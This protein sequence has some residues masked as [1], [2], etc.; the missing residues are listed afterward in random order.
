[1][2]SRHALLAVLSLVLLPACEEKP[3]FV[4]SGRDAGPPPVC[5]GASAGLVCLGDVA[6]QC[7]ARGVASMPDDCGGRGERCVPDVGCRTCVPREVRCDG[8]TIEVCDGEESG[9]M[10]GATCDASAGLRCSADGCVDLCAR[11]AEERSYLGCEYWPVVTANA[12]LRSELSF[13]VAI[14]NPQLVPALVRI[15]RGGTELA[16]RTIAPGALEIVELPWIES[17][18]APPSLATV[19]EP[20]GAYHLV[21]DVP[22][23]V[24]QWS[25]LQ[26][27]IDRD[28]ADEPVIGDRQ[29]F[30]Y[31]NDASLLLPAHVLTGNYV[32]V[33]RPTFMLRDGAERPYAASPGFASIVGAAEGEVTVEIEARGRVA[34]SADGTFAAMMPGETRTVTLA[35]GEV[36]Q[37]AS[38][39]AERCPGTERAESSATG[40]GVTYCDPGDAYD[41]SG[42]ILRASG[43]VAVVAG[44]DCTFVPFDRWACDHLEEQLFPVE[45]LGRS[46]FVAPTRPLREEPNLLR[47]VSAADDN[48]ITFT[49]AIAPPVTLDRGEHVEIELREGVRVE[50]TGALLAALFLVGQDY[51]GL[52]TSGRQGNGDPSMALAIPDAQYRTRYTVLTPDSYRESWIDV[53]APAGARIEIDGRLVTGWREIAGTGWVHASIQVE[54][55]AHAARGDR[56]F[57]LQVYGFGAYTSY[58]VSGGLDLRPIA[59][60]I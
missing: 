2:T 43:P 58:L 30:S 8:E 23:V 36:L 11:A 38:E 28:C 16:S 46:A 39:A 41:L 33:S 3:P 9:W 54:P 20:G 12:Q 5:E 57:G 52:G 55:G 29:C 60:P 35:R 50:G 13:A 26:F 47:V 32:V 24:T 49:P 44:H 34:A 10:R 6:W 22:V 21:S 31:T 18:R 53:I 45:S 51:G 37:L 19:R 7:D 4:P 1:M 27:R 56:A 15:D 14:A 40:A 42:T 48:A 59:P 17:L 25:P